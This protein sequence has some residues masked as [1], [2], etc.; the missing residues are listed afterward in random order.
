M[1]RSSLV[2]A[3]LL[4]GAV[5]ARADVPE[6]PKLGTRL[7]VPERLLSAARAAFPDTRAVGKNLLA[8]SFNPNLFLTARTSVSVTFLSEAA[9]FRNSLGYFAYETDGDRVR[10][11]ERGLVFPNASGEGSGGTLS[12]GDTVTLR[13]A[14]GQVRY[15]EA[16]THV[17]FFLVANGWTGSGV[18]GWSPEQPALPASSASQNPDVFSSLDLLNP[19][20]ALGRPE[21]ARHAAMLR[22]PGL[23]GFLGTKPF[24]LLGFEDVRRD[25]GSDEDFND[26]LCVVHADLASALN[27]TRVATFEPAATDADGDGVVGLRDAFANDPLRASIRPTWGAAGMM[28]AQAETEEILDGQEALKDL[29]ATF[30]RAAEAGESDLILRGFPSSARG[31]IR[32]ERY[33][34]AGEHIVEHAIP[35][36]DLLQLESDGTAGLKLPAA[37]RGGEAGQVESLRLVITFDQPLASTT[38]ATE[39]GFPW[40]LSS[41]TGSAAPARVAT[42]WQRT[43]GLQAGE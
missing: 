40:Q 32:V 5:R 43:W 35:L 37:F 26:L 9:M 42:P 18:R 16:G 15:F 17:G 30:H 27:A 38:F 29:Q 12:T 7:E 14:A 20:M 2:A 10:I 24:L 22:V 19:E 3:I 39:G 36:I 31:M 33:T 6:R 28:G 21:L 34:G 11:L 13:D 1:R 25:Q 4:L 8:P 23:N 41:R